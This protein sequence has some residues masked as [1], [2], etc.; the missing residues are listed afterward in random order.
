MAAD[1]TDVA[2]D[3]GPDKDI[4]QIY[5]FIN[6]SS[7]G[8]RAGE[9]LKVHEPGDVFRL[10]E[11]GFRAE[12]RCFNI[13]DGK[14]GQKPGFIEVKAK[15]EVYPTVRVMVAGGD[16]TVMWAITELIATNI[17]TSKVALGVIPFGTGNDFSRT[18]QWGA[19]PANVLVGPDKARLKTDMR[20]WCTADVT[21]FDVWNI[22]ITTDV[23]GGFKFVHDGKKSLTE[24]DMK[25][26][27]ITKIEGGGMKMVKP[28][29]NYF[30][31]GF[32]ERAGLG[33]EKKRTK[34]K[35][36]NLVRYAVEGGKKFCCKQPPTVA[37]V[38]E[39]LTIGDAPADEPE[40]PRATS[41]ST[42]QVTTKAPEQGQDCFMGTPTEML[43]LNIPS[44]AGGADPWAWTSKKG[45][46]KKDD[47]ADEI[48]I[49]KL[50]QNIGD[51]KLEIITYS[52]N[53]AVNN[54]IINSKTPWFGRGSGKRLCQSE[55]PFFCAFKAPDVAK[56]KKEGRVY[57]QIDGEFFVSEY[58]KS[59]VV[60]HGQSI[61]VLSNVGKK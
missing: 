47:S 29:I 14:P 52:S 31:F 10:E 48:D 9:Y 5:M 28:M 32:L 41:P 60:K 27:C 4:Q 16:G 59:F 24:G 6:P 51:K 8:N 34:S 7:G 2:V 11:E 21:S 56:Y 44:F 30:S 53:M 1:P 18:L 61:Q 54:D 46:I 35:F 25:Q 43:F 42:R 58:P 23:Q 33:F 19:A 40:G 45:Y 17:D 39:T 50:A 57:F 13:R 55:G 15:T 26:H 22:E 37:D 12:L 3:V 20:L 36:G 49:T 38:M